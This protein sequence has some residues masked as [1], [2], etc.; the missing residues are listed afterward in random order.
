MKATKTTV[1]IIIAFLVS[2]AA[3]YGDGGKHASAKALTQAMSES[4]QSQAPAGQEPQAALPRSSG[5]DEIIWTGSSA[6]YDIQ[7]STARIIG[8]RA[9]DQKPI[10]STDDLISMDSGSYLETVDEGVE[11]QM[12]CSYDE[13]FA[14][15]SVVGHYVTISESEYD[16]CVGAAHP[17]SFQTWIAMDMSQ[18][19]P[20]QAL[21]SNRFGNDTNNESLVL[22]DL[23]PENDVFDAL[24]S[25]GYAQKA[26]REKKIKTPDSLKD[27]V[28]VLASEVG[29]EYG[30]DTDMLSRFAFHHLEGDRVA[31]RLGISNNSAQVCNKGITE[32]GLLLP[33]PEALRDSLREA[34]A[35]RCGYLMK[36]LKSIAGG[37]KAG[38][39]FETEGPIRIKER[40]HPDL[41][42][43]FFS[44]LGKFGSDGEITVKKVRVSEALE[45]FQ[46]QF[47]A[48]L[49]ML[50]VI[51]KM[52]PLPRDSVVMFVEDLDFDGYK[53]F[54]LQTHE[55]EGFAFNDYW[56]FDAQSRKF[57]YLGNYPTL[58]P[59]PDK[60]E[61]TASD[62]G[63]DK[64]Y[65]VRNAKLVLIR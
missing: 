9:T 5:K 55:H 18:R 53:D 3:G 19:S 48:E 1:G 43:Y 32:I 31:V 62:P 60:H 20:G 6:G 29:C 35:R 61:L 16:F 34:D 42:D 49:Q 14:L 4:G 36:D 24:R 64:V 2:G 52:K 65:Q 58:V 10:F 23:F 59:D 41:P 28:A 30:F 33:I 47:A 12:E 46:I 39:H 50:D 40:I 51:T 11:E 26:L 8:A 13:S 44:A 25:D 7:W 37:K 63:G 17:N 56:L 54:G 21:T 45:D 27:L 22:T 57:E 15:L 38:F